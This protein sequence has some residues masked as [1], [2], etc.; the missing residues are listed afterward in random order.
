MVNKP[1][2]KLIAAVCLVLA[3]KWNEPAILKATALLTLTLTLTLTLAQ[4]QVI[5]RAL[6]TA[7]SLAACI[8]RCISTHSAAYLNGLITMLPLTQARGTC[9]VKALLPLLKS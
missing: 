1:N 9:L 8:V 4:P 7:A 6:P 2:R 5:F 3:A